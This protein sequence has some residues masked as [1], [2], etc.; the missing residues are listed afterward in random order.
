MLLGKCRR[1]QGD[2]RLPDI[3]SNREERG[4]FQPCACKEVES[5]RAKRIFNVKYKFKSNF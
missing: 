1:S 4:S 3:D 5:Q 2:A